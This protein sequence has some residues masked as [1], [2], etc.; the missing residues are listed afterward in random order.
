MVHKDQLI[1]PTFP[2]SR[3]IA[4]NL[5]LSLYLQVSRDLALYRRQA[6]RKAHTIQITYCTGARLEA[7]LGAVGCKRRVGLETWR[8]VKSSPKGKDRV[9]FLTC[10]AQLI[11]GERESSVKNPS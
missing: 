4:N 11:E 8:G 10:R 5:C 9:D 2:T 6:T 3:V 7:Q 1:L